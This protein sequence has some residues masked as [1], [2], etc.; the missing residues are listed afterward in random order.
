MAVTVT[1]PDSAVEP[2][3][4]VEPLELLPPQLTAPSIRASKAAEPQA[5]TRRCLRS[6][7]RDIVMTSPRRSKPKPAGGRLWNLRQKGVRALLAAVMVTVVLPEVVT[8]VLGT[9]Q[10]TF[11]RELE[12]AQLNETVPVKFLYGLT[13]IVAV[14]E[15]PGWTVSVVGFDVI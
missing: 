15:A 7:V 1:V 12:T 2:P 11:T 9:E 6:R 10:V 13:L 3:P 14:P 8:V 4:P 5:Y